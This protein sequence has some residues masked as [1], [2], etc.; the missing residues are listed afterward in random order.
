MP[1]PGGN[2][3]RAK[4]IFRSPYGEIQ[5]EWWIYDHSGFHLGTEVPPNTK[6]E[7]RLPG[8]ASDEV[9]GSGKYSFHKRDYRKTF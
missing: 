2:I 5:A 3:T 1:I 4:S 9:V 8:D 6:A 7:V